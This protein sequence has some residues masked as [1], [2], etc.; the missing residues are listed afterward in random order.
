MPHSCGRGI[1]HVFMTCPCVGTVH[2][3]FGQTTTPEGL[4]M[5]YIRNLLPW[6]G[7]VGHWKAFETVCYEMHGTKDIL[8]V[9]CSTQTCLEIARFSLNVA[10]KH[11]RPFCG[12]KIL[13]P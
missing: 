6:I 1:L 2:A 11:G 4:C 5:S 3:I 12:V 8:K 13:T 9:E 10:K 7:R